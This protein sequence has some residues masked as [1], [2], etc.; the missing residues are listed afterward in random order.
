MNS[1]EAR[2]T[3]KGRITVPAKVRAKL[4]LKGGDKLEFSIDGSG[5]VLVRPRT[6]R[7]VVVHENVRK[8]SP[9]LKDMDND[10]VI[11]AAVIEKDRRN[12]RRR[13]RRAR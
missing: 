1:F 2:V 3:A 13:S 5:R 8:T 12:Q 9:V 6:A 11:D 10:E 7:P 4:G